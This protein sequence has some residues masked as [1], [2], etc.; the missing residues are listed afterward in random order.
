[1]ILLSPV[2]D[3]RLTQDVN[4]ALI[5]QIFD[6]ANLS[7]INVTNQEVLVWF[8]NRLKPLLANLSESVVSPLFTILS[9]RDCNITQSV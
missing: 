4:A 8:Q 3:V 6:R 7:N 5:K 9:T 2:Q 1:M